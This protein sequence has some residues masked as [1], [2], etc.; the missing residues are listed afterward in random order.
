[1]VSGILNYEWITNDNFTKNNKI[2][3]TTCVKPE[4]LKRMT[5]EGVLKKMQTEFE[6]QFNII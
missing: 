5:Y 4:T 3:L 1:M 2:C 6:I